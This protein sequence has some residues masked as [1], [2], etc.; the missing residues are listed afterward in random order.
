MGIIKNLIWCQ[1]ANMWQCRICEKYFESQLMHLEECP[2]SAKIFLLRRAKLA[3]AEMLIATKLAKLGAHPEYISGVINSLPYDAEN[4]KTCP[5]WRLDN[6]IKLWRY[7][8]PK[9]IVEG[10]GKPRTPS[11]TIE[12]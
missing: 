9:K 7:R 12:D 10:I 3:Q 11:H 2:D 1:A 4:L 5:T 6:L 8:A